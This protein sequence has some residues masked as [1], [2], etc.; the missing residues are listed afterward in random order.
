MKRH[1][2]IAIIGFPNPC[3]HPSV[4]DPQRYEQRVA[5]LMQLHNCDHSDAEGIADAESLN[6]SPQ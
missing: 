5:E 3:D 2:V 1:P 4:L 6:V